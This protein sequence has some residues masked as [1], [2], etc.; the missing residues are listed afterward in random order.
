MRL[1]LQENQDVIAAN[2]MIQNPNLPPEVQ[3][4]I[5]SGKPAT[6][7]QVAAM[8]AAGVD[9]D[10]YAA[11][12]QR[13]ATTGPIKVA[14]D[15]YGGNLQR[16]Q[17]EAGLPQT[18]AAAAEA[19]PSVKD[20]ADRKVATGEAKTPGEGLMQ[21]WN[22]LG[23]TGQILAVGGI[24]LGAIGL[25]NMFMGEGGAGS[26]LMMLLG[27]GAMLGAGQL[28]GM[29]P[30]GMSDA[31]GGIGEALGLGNMLT[32]NVPMVPKLGP[33]GKPVLGV[34]GKPVMQPRAPAAASLGVG[35]PNAAARKAL[36]AMPPAR[37]D[38]ELAK[39]LKTNKDLAA[40]LA[41]ATGIIGRNAPGVVF[42][43]AQRLIPDIT[44]P[45]LDALLA[46]Y[47]RLKA[48]GQV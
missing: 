17:Q 15:K 8:K 37:Q 18:A 29:L 46:S 16:A 33:D 11:M 3:A 44:Q 31:I 41:S 24:A 45:E 9:T 36:M 5:A 27:G 25:M 22:D 34:G 23:T 32:P 40:G 43:R 42:S 13:L 28:G 26:I 7:D 20:A 10:Q 4:L 2:A 39:M 1:A 19:N 30:E 12:S 21:V 38:I 47:N 48:Q 6:P 14:I 35:L